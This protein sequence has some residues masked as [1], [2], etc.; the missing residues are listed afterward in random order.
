M[1]R[2]LI[3]I[4]DWYL[5]WSSIVDAPI[6]CCKKDELSLMVMQFFNDQKFADCDKTPMV[7]DTDSTVS[8][9]RA[10]PKE[11]QLTKDEIYRVYCLRESL[12]GWSPYND[13][14]VDTP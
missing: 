1:P 2:S 3:K 14:F 5:V 10:G 9:N 13:D 12:D 8:F 11:K 4:K 7:A 6:A